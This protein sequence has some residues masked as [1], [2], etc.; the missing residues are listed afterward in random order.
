[1]D[2][3]KLANLE[4]SRLV[5]QDHDKQ[6]WQRMDAAVAEEFEL[7]APLTSWLIKRGAILE[8]PLTKMVLQHEEIPE[9]DSTEEGFLSRFGLPLPFTHLSIIGLEDKEEDVRAC[10]VRVAQSVEGMLFGKVKFEG[11]KGLTD[12]ASVEMTDVE[13]AKKALASIKFYGPYVLVVGN[14]ESIE[15]IDDVTVL[16]AVSGYQFTKQEMMLVQITP[17]VVRIVIAMRPTLIVWEGKLKVICCITPQV[18][19]DLARKSGIAWR[20]T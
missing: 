8:V 17:D 2:R 1:M 14:S 4:E 16:D 3:Y 13:Q 18:R 19:T 20:R 5:T 6:W 7:F 12:L 10:A 9:D 11:I 15:G